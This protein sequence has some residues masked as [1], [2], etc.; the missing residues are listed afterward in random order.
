MKPATVRIILAL[1]MQ[2]H[3]SL[4]QLDV[5][6]AFL[7]GLL[8]EKV[9][10]SQPPGYVDPTNPSHVC[11]LHKAVYGLKPAPMAWF[12][13]FTTQLFHLG[14]ISSSADSN[15]F[16]LH[17]G[18]C[19]VYLLLYVDD[20]IVTR[21]DPSFIDQLITRLSV[22]SDLKDLGPLRFFLGLQIEYTP[23][24][25]F[26]HQSKYATN[27]LTKFNM[28]DCK[29]CLTPCSPTMHVNSQ[30]SFV[31]VDPTSYSSMVVALQYLTFT[32]PNLSY[33][34]Q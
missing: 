27:L 10:M 33:S 21:N 4:K 14:F 32:R 13:S 25:L 5:S 3:W 16:I 17:H 24:G 28:M 26:A 22:V 19:V 8:H 2:H 30:T 34:V 20:I 15:L 23:Q 18:S 12:E 1:A 29:P 31:L 11:L 7:H 9:F 6:N